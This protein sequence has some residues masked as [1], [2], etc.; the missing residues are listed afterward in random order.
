MQEKTFHE[1][2]L[3]AWSER[4]SQYDVLFASVSTQAIDDILD[5]LGTLQGKRHLDVACGTG[6]LVAAAAKRGAVSE[7]I[8]FAPA[9]VAAAQANY[10]RE[11]FQVGDAVELFYEDESF[12]IVTCS[13]GL[14]NM[15]NPQAAIDEAFRVLKTGGYFAFTLWYG[16]EGGNEAQ[17]IIK[18]ALA[19][20]AA[21]EITLPEKWTQLRNADE[22]ACRVIT[23]QS[24]FG[25]PTFKRL[26]IVWHASSA[27]E[28][29]DLFDKL[30]V[31]TKLVI[32]QQPTAAQELI[33]QRVL[34]EAEARRT[35]GFIPLDWPAL[36]TVVEKPHTQRG[37]K[38]SSQLEPKYT[39]FDSLEKMLAPKTLSEFFSESTASVD[40]QQTE[41][42]GGLAGGQFSYVETD[43]RRLV[44]KRMS[45][46]SD[47]LMF[48]S[49]D[50]RGRAV[51][52]WQYGLLDELRPHL[53]HK[54]IACAHDDAGWA[55]LM[56]D[57]TE[58]LFGGW[59]NQASLKLL[60]IFLDRMA[61]LHATF[62]DDPR[63]HDPR[64]GLCDSAMRLDVTS[65]TLAQNHPGDQRGVIPDWIREGW[66][67]MES[68]LDQD[69]FVQLRQLR[70][71]P[72]PLLDAMDRYPYTL[73]HGDYRNAN[74]A[75]L[76]PDQ[77]V[78]FDWQM[79]AR[80]LMTVDLAWFTDQWN[81][82][83]DDKG[84]AK[85]QSY[86]RKRLET[87][88][89]RRFEDTVWQPMVEL[90]NLY[91]ILFNTCLAAFWYKHTD[92]PELRQFLELRLKQRNQQVRASMRWL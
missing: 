36:L 79:A 21:K 7:G 55:I 2:E 43:T 47:W 75:Y 6:H 62:W 27:Q 8:D 69:V 91:N 84:K 34:S 12:D 3:E 41:D 90:G 86:Y 13:F 49:N 16:V 54:I 20:H 48:A 60:R 45:H 5:S 42:L 56:E 22:Q 74:L 58:G 30:S 67:I 87:Y 44:L 78:A 80:S 66:K 1:I 35:N 92:D 25:N 59:E 40:I 33:Y 28:V 4:A 14:S 46:A 10:P 81:Y 9:M 82:L 50:L 15:E 63:L 17:A 32:E 23:Q 88:L 72:Q 39:L 24:G 57:L 73:V 29:A 19:K 26:P 70:D 61:K 76:K 52:L 11:H 89:G 85:L 83:L 51:T 31:R 37:I 38:T 71:D 18:T 65:L 68:S 53:E 77:A 64:L